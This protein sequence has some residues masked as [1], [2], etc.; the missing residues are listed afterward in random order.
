MQSFW[1]T[2]SKRIFR[3]CSLAFGI[4]GLRR[5]W[6][7]ARHWA[8]PS[9]ALQA[10]LIIGKSVSLHAPRSTLHVFHSAFR[11]PHSAFLLLVVLTLSAFSQPFTFQRQIAPFPVQDLAG[12]LYAL[13]FTGG[14]NRPVLQLVDIDGDEAPD[15][16]VQDRASLLTFFRNTGT[17]QAY[18]FE[19]VTD[20]YADL[21]VGDWFKFADV[22]GD[23][24]LD[25]F[26]EK[27]F[28][29]IR[30]YRNDGDAQNPAFVLARDELRDAANQPINADDLSIPDWA[31]LDCDGDLELF[32]GRILNGTVT[33]YDLTGFTPDNVPIYTFVT[34]TFQSLTILTGGGDRPAGNAANPQLHGANSLSFADID[35]DQDNDLFWGD[36][37]AN[38]VLFLENSGSCATPD[39]AIAFEQY[40]PNAPVLT[41]GYNVPRFADID[42]DGD[43]DMF[44]GVL[45]GAGSRIIDLAENLYFYENTGSPSQPTFTLSTRQLINSI[46]VGRNSIIRLVDIDS[47]GDLDLFLAPQE[48]LASPNHSN[49][50]LHYY[51]NI[52]GAANPQFKLVNTNY[53]QYDK[54]YDT[55]YAPAF[56]DLDGDSD[57]DLIVGKYDGK[58]SY[59][60]NDGDPQHPDLVL[61]SENYGGIDIGNN[62]N[63]EFADIDGDGDRD[64]FIGEYNGNLNFYRNTGTVANPVFTLESN[65]YFG[66][67]VGDYS[68]PRFTDIDGD[69][70]LDLLVGSD[71]QGISFYR[72]T[73]TPQAANFVP[74]A[75]LSFPLHLFTSPQLADIDADGDLDMLSGSDGGGII[76]YD[77]REIVA[78]VEPAPGGGDFPET[79]R[80]LGN[81]PN[82]FNPETVIRYQLSVVSEVELA[83]YDLLGRKIVNLVGARQAAGEYRVQW[84]GRDQAGRSVVSGVYIYRLSVGGTAQSRKMILMR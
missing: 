20:Q 5:H 4:I 13:P 54:Q 79:F 43:Q 25:L 10:S 46:D 29:S 60:R 41:G 27:P 32:L 34:D 58:L 6:R 12:D 30:Y 75:T 80:L 83:V 9:L 31:D 23:N 69:N 24:D 28:G 44:V 82:P 61:V 40:P 73:G 26:A 57:L 72:N 49:S 68:C 17:P 42:S 39:I 63:P 8:S 11:T 52:G 18:E 7:F 48:D 45:G 33:M 15:L 3:T 21:E 65:D 71:N 14:M 35:N 81:Y 16:F 22:D 1:E 76:Y 62:S 56:L 38:S 36:F 2:C 51:Q 66:I 70:D 50:R 74:D 37:F 84:D 53:L 64:L 59:F 47:D 67:D 55:N 78:G 77:N 19:W